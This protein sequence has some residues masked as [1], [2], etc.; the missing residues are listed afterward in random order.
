[1]VGDRADDLECPEV[2]SGCLLVRR[3]AVERDVRPD[4][5][6][7]L[8]EVE[9]PLDLRVED[10][11]QPDVLGL[12]VGLMTS[13]A[14]DDDAAIRLTQTYLDA[15]TR[16]GRVG[17]LPIA[18]NCRATLH[19][20]AGEIGDAMRLT[21]LAAEARELTGAGSNYV[22]DLPLAAW[23]GKSDEVQ[24]LSRLAQ[25]QASRHGG[26]RILSS[27]SY[28]Q[29]VPFNALCRYDRAISPLPAHEVEIGFRASIPPEQVEAAV[30]V[31]DR[32]HARDHAQLVR[33]YATAAATPW[34][35]G[36]DLR[37]RA[38]LEDG[39]VES[40]YLGSIEA[41]GYS[42]SSVQRARSQ[43]LYGEWLRRR[44]RPTESR[45][46]LREAYEAFSAL[47]VEAF[48]QRAARE[49]RALGEDTPSAETRGPLTAQQLTVAR[50]AARGIT[51]KEI[52]GILT[53]SPRTVDTHLRSIFGR[54]GVTSR[55]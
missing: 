7:A 47:A 13:L 16:Q 23:R 42:R 34:A 15:A 44:R 6:R 30:R 38:L 26:R 4:R 11:L 37:C 48:A 43:L 12:G 46:V 33:E 40:L 18:L 45:A 28:A 3:E 32:S 25:E 52:A 31:G 8:G 20:H 1:V 22:V 55:R 29:M 49:L 21:T 54:L 19:L 35:S 10:R 14:W 41:L 50:L 36:M 53:V 5:C 17:E 39:E 2:L 9:L 27:A 24:R 51:T